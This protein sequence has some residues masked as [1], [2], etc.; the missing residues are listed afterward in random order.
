MTAAAVV[1]R[2]LELPPRGDRAVRA[3]A[4]ALGV[5][6]DGGA[7]A[8]AHVPV[9]PSEDGAAAGQDGDARWPVVVD[10]HRG[11][12]AA[13]AV[14][15]AL[16]GPEPP[17]WHQVDDAAVRGRAKGGQPGSRTIATWCRVEGERLRWAATPWPTSTRPRTQPARRTTSPPRCCVANITRNADF[18]ML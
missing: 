15:D 9:D 14:L 16:A 13:A 17:P 1:L 8:K 7:R 10:G 2:G 11:W 5:A 18:K 12:S 3:L 4:P 6:M